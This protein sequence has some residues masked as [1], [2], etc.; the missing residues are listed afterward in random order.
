VVGVR[1]DLATAAVTQGKPY[2]LKIHGDW[3]NRDERILTRGD[4]ERHY[5]DGAGVDFT[6]PLPTQLRMLMQNRPLLFLG[7]GLAGDRL[8]EILAD[9]ARS[10]PG[11][12]HFAVVER[13]AEAAAARVRARFLSERNVTPIWYPAGR[14]ELLRPLLE[15]LSGFTPT[16]FVPEARLINVPP[17]NDFFTGREEILTEL[18]ELL[19]RENRAALKQAV[20]GLGGVGKTQVMIEYAHRQAR[21]FAWILWTNAESES[22]LISGFIALAERLKL[23]PRE[24]AD[25][26]IQE[27]KI[28]LATHDNWL[29]IF[30]NADA[31]GVVSKFL[32]PR[33]TGK[34]ALTSRAQN[35]SELGLARFIEIDVMTPTE[36]L[37]FLMKRSGRAELSTAEETAARELADELGRLPLALEQVAAYAVEKKAAFADLLPEIRRRLNQVL[38]QMP[39]QAGDYKPD[40][41]TRHRHMVATTWLM[42]FTQVEMESPAAAD[43]LRMSAFLAPDAIPLEVVKEGAEEIGPAVADALKVLVLP[44][45]VVAPLWR[46]S[47]PQIK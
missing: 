10:L 5:G 11:V 16:P 8:T 3:K 40:R 24:K 14:H 43:V 27:V 32:P 30:D 29:L 25:E 44:N 15:W 26:I 4:Y 18:H 23:P 13:P 33:M 28:W 41:E 37:A 20:A 7:C 39:P 6:K 2:L 12:E 17:R 1:A 47:L 46:Y 35:F 22:A 38:A 36:A 45:D 34:I 42:N 19:K 9:I 21:N 31:P